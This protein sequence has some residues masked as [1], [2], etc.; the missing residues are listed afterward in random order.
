MIDA[1]VVRSFFSHLEEAGVEEITSVLTEVRVRA[2][3]RVI[4]EGDMDNAVYLVV[5][6]VLKGVTANHGGR[7]I[8]N[9]L[10]LTGDVFFPSENFM[11]AEPAVCSV[12]ACTDALLYVADREAAMACIMKYP[13][14][15]IAFGDYSTRSACRH[16]DFHLALTSM[17]VKKRYRWFV[18]TYPEAAGCMKQYEVAS[19]LGVTPEHLSSVVRAVRAEMN[20]EKAEA[21]KQ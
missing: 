18:E 19:L 10:E 12:I 2:G 13:V 21:G 9:T 7:E 4:R 14:L 8:V 17:D 6:G 11:V 5:S 1:I 16:R 15:T 3:T 20:T